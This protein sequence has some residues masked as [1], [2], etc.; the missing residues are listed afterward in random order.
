MDDREK[1]IEL[2]HKSVDILINTPVEGYTERLAD[3]L[4][5]NGVV[6]QTQGEWWWMADDI[7]TYAICSNC[8][9]KQ[10]LDGGTTFEDICEYC[11]YC[12]TCGAKMKEVK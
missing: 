5:A 10:V 1:L 6:I 11:H 3:Y 4:I 8:F 12:P 2:L 7:Y 9:E